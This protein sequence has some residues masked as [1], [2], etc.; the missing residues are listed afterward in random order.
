MELYVQ[1]VLFCREHSFN[2][3]QTSTL[4]SIIKSIHEANV[5]KQS[6]FILT[7][8]SQQ[9][10]GLSGFENDVFKIKTVQIISSPHNICLAQTQLFC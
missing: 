9:G 10:G 1:T 5:G 2:K 6:S 3:E 4:L 7:M 8:C